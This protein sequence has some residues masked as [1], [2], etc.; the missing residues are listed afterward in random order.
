MAHLLYKGN[1]GVFDCLFVLYRN[2]N[3]CTDWDEIWHEVVLEGGR[4]LGVSTQYE[5]GKG[6][7][8]CLWSLNC[9]FWQQLY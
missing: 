1:V 3:C 9:A 4:F 6:G 7:P 5:V 8:K 2:P